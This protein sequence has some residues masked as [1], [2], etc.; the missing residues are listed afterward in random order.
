MFLSDSS[1]ESLFRRLP[2]L[3]RNGAYKYAPGTWQGVDVS[4]RP[5]MVSYDLLNF[6]CCVYLQGNEGLIGYQKSIEPN[7]PWADDHFAER[8]CGYPLNP[9]TQWE[10]WPWAKSAGEFVDPHTGQFNHNYMERLWPKLAG[11]YL[12]SKTVEQFMKLKQRFEP[13]V[14]EG[15]RQPYGDL[16]DLVKMLAT[17]RDTRK[18]YIPLFF[19]EDT[20]RGKER[21]P[22][23]LGYQLRWT[24]DHKLHI[25]YPM[26]SCDVIRH[27][28]DD[29]YMAVRLLLWVLDRCREIDPYWKSVVPGTYS[30][31]C[32]SLHLF[33]NDWRDFCGTEA[34]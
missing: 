12:A 30:M 16:M 34:P 21:N 22:C 23:T 19:P 29:I 20:G 9:G 26:R 11:Q 3:F 27:F 6:D 28:R 15:I 25:W 18:A 2:G 7:L 13:M 17:T 14:N 8:V 4:K 33:K 24:P 32:T 5:E 31:H 1:F 10:H